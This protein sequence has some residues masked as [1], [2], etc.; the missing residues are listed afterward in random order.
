[1]FNSIAAGTAAGTAA[2]VTNKND[3]DSSSGMEIVCLLVVLV[4]QTEVKMKTSF[5]SRP[6]DYHQEY[7][8]PP[9]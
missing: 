9:G 5:C 7:Q 3:F 4:S 8:I 2:A 1:M 6:S